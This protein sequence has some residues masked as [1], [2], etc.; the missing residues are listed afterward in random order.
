VFFTPSIFA[1]D[2]TLCRH[3]SACIEW[4]YS[5]YQCFPKKML[6]LSQVRFLA[7]RGRVSSEVSALR[8]Q[9]LASVLDVDR[10]AHTIQVAGA[11]FALTL[12]SATEMQ[13]RSD[14]DLL[15][16]VSNGN[17]EAL[18]LLFQRHARAVHNV[19]RRILKDDSEAEDLLQEL[20]LFIFQKARSFDATKG[21]ATSWIIQMAYHR[22]FDR[23]RYLGFRQH[24]N[25]QEF[26]EARLAGNQG[27]ISIDEIAGRSLLEKLRKELSA[28]QLQTLELHFFEGYSFHEIAEKTSQTFGN[29]RNHYY[30]GLERLRSHIFPGKTNPK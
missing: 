30:R 16:Q 12:N 29:V 21:S 19:A 9:S 6:G 26:E 3:Y 18:S 7:Q 13:A 22:A 8:S 17:K 11:E 27:Q 20:F 14:E 10:S 5:A 24:Y 25:S 2:A 4:H 28:E 15:L 1:I 23:R